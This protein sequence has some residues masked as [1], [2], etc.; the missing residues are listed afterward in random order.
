MYTLRFTRRLL[1]DVS[2]GID[3]DASQEPTTAL[4]DWYV[5]PV[6]A[7]QRR[8]LLCTSE[9]SLLSVMLPAEDIDEL[10]EHL[11]V[12]LVGV[13]H[14]LG[15]P[16][17]V[18]A[19]EIDA[20]TSGD[21]GAAHNRSTLGSMRGLATRARAFLAASRG[22]ID[23]AALYTH[24]GEYRS[25]AA[26]PHTAAARAVALLTARPAVRRAASTGRRRG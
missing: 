24:L 21:T 22:E 18:V 6:L 13:L 16:R 4:G 7:K 17:T 1:A 25:G 23:V 20:M 8:L 3:D 11:A 12:A 10:P 26:G 9:R 2:A 19:R 15:V 5:A 14:R